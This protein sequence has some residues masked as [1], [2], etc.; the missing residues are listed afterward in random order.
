MN[1]KALFLKVERQRL[2]E[3]LSTANK[4]PKLGCLGKISAKAPEQQRKQR[5]RTEVVLLMPLSANI[6][7]GPEGEKMANA[8]AI[9]EKKLQKQCWDYI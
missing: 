9:E 6:W 7:A 8:P 3:T 5:P 2:R 4:T 1:F